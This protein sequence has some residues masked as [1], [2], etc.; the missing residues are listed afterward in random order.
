MG[1]ASIFGQV[2]HKLSKKIINEFLIEYEKIQEINKENL[3]KI[4]KEL[5]S[6]HNINFKSIGQ[7]LRIVLTGSKF[8]PGIYDIL[9]SLNKEEVVKRLK[10]I[11]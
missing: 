8:G 1:G 10:I 7:P 6:A 5:I 11:I 9:L 4:I 3:E 2:L